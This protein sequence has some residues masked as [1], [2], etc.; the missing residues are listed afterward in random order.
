MLA[1]LRKIIMQLFIGTKSIKARAMNRLDYNSYRG[2][3]L[4][5]DEN[6]NDE[7]F[8]VEYIDGG[9][10]NHPDHV[11]YISW[12][13]SEVFNN[14]YKAVSKGVAFGCA[15]ELAKSGAKIART[16]W[17]GSGMYAII[18]PGFP[19]GVPA[20][21][22][23]AIAHNVPVGTIISVRPYWSLKTAQGDLAMW[24]P[25]GSDS[26]ADDWIVID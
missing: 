25:S 26:L 16:G 4:P 11:G 10:S 23:T 8:L 7:G 21:E 3:E 6:G 19:D 12:S 24:A 5:S 20:N 13:P 9:E 1:I 22:D 18:M 2:W 17:N 14:A 15:V